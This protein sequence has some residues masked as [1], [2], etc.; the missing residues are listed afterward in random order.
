MFA[1]QKLTSIGL[2][3]G[4]MVA[5]LVLFQPSA[6]AF[7]IPE[8]WSGGLRAYGWDSNPY[9]RG[10]RYDLVCTSNHY[11]NQTCRLPRGVNG[12]IKLIKKIS[13]SPCVLGQTWGVGERSVWVSDGCRAVFRL[14]QGRGNGGWGGEGGGRGGEGQPYPHSRKRQ[15]SCGSPHGHYQAC[16]LR[17]AGRRHV[18][19]ARQV[20]NSACIRNVTW[21]VKANEIWV[22]KGCR[23]VFKFSGKRPHY[24]SPS[25]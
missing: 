5:G 22:N 3:I 14:G 1:F 16:H 2:A 9:S 19:L 17:H 20:S 4:A 6:E 10:D 18:R 13:Q 23:A 25:E 8:N 15:L 12:H 7:E 24:W 11:R 21:G